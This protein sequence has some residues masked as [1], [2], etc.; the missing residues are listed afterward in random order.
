MPTTALSHFNQDIARARALVTEAG[1]A[2]KEVRQIQSD[3]LK[4]GLTTTEL[5]QVVSSLGAAAP[6]ELRELGARLEARSTLRDDLYRSAWMFAVGAMDAY[7]SDAYADTLARILTAKRR[8]PLI[9]VPLLSKVLLPMDAILSSYAK[10]DNWKWRMAARSLMSDKNILDVD[11]VKGYLN[12]MVHG[13]KLFK[14]PVLQNWIALPGWERWFGTQGV[15]LQAYVAAGAPVAG[16]APPTWDDIRK[17]LNERFEA[18]CQRRHDC[19]HNCDRPSVKP[20]AIRK[21]HVVDTI[22]DI[23][24]LVHRIDDWLDSGFCALLVH[25]GFNAVTRNAVGC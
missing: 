16:G 21:S 1:Q 13:D 12:K 3:A 10:R 19:I 17:A 14:N 15:V 8:E 25:L 9:D 22:D 4:I 23:E 20:Q 18:V 24:W 2:A 5:R 7:F 11:V 6:K